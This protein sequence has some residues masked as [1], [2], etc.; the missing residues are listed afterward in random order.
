MRVKQLMAMVYPWTL[1]HARLDLRKLC[2]FWCADCKQYWS[3][4]SKSQIKRSH[5]FVSSLVW[6]GC[7]WHINQLSVNSNIAYIVAH[8]HNST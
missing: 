7:Q 8:V 5:S 3:T 2:R 1:V 6:Y 4:R